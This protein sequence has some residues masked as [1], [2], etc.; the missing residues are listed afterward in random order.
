MRMMENG[1]LQFNSYV[2]MSLMM[3]VS[4]M[5]VLQ[6]GGRELFLLLQ[7]V[8]CVYMALTTWKLGVIRYAAINGIF[9]ELIVCAISAITGNLPY[10]YKKAA[11]VMTVYMIPFY[12][13]AYYM[14]SML[15]HD[16][17]F[18]PVLRRAIKMMCLIQLCWIPLQYILYHIANIDINQ[19]VFV[20]GLHMVENA[21]FYRSWEYHPSGLSWH[22]AVLAPM[23]VFAMVMF[24]SIPVRLLVLLDASICGN[25]TSLIGALL[26]GALLLFFRLPRIRWATPRV[27]RITLWVVVAA[28][29]FGALLSLRFSIWGAIWDRV[30][31]M[32]TRFLAG[33]D[34]AS[35]AA[36]MGYF[37]DYIPILR[38]SSPMQILF[39]YGLGCSGYPIS[40]MYDRYTTLASWSIECDII[41]ILVSR[42]VIGFALYYYF[43]IYI[44]VQG[45]KQDYRYFAVM[46]PVLVQ[47]FGY[48]IQWDYVVMLEIIMYCCIKQKVCF[49]SP[50]PARWCSAVLRTT[51]ERRRSA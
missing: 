27:R 16:V 9:L 5:V 37:K 3:V 49:F 11:V 22:S 30:T 26:C 21:S 48:N 19:I 25:T 2:L 28:A 24:E 39:G 43:L 6:F 33:S 7:I 10:S 23:F 32:F 38:Q 44:A 15:E 13:A 50:E 36:H 47:G 42:G 8:F 35:T 12:F 40:V 18:L 17:R 31:Y 46:L 45:G 34:D 20:D 41:N 4:S 14:Q 51:A 1:K 29:V